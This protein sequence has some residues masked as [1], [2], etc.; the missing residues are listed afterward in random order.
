MSASHTDIPSK[1]LKAQTE[2]CKHTQPHVHDSA[3]SLRDLLPHN[4]TDPMARNSGNTNLAGQNVSPGL[5][6]A[7]SLSQLMSEHA[8][9]SK[10]SGIDT[11]QGFGISSLGS[12]PVG[13][14]SHNQNSLSLGTLASLNMSAASPGSAPSLLS[15]SLSSLSLNNPKITTT[16]SS[17]APPPGFGSLNLALQGNR[18]PTGVVTGVKAPVISPKGGP[19]LADLIQEHSNRSPTAVNSFLVQKSSTTSGTSEGPAVPAQSLSLSELAMQHENKKTSTEELTNMLTTSK[20]TNIAPAC[21]GGTVSLS[22]LALQQQT[23]SKPRADALKQP[24]ASSDMLSL[25]HLESAHKGKTSTTSNGSEYSL[26]SLLLPAK[27]ESAGVLAES[28][29]EGGTKRLN[30]RPHHQSSRTPKPMQM[31]DLSTLMAQSE[32]KCPR[33]SEQDLPSPVSPPPVASVFAKP[34]VFALTLS[35]QNRRQQRRMRNVL[36]GKIRTQRDGSGYQAFL[37]SSQEKAKEQQP[38]PSPIEPFTFDTPS[39]D[40][41]VRANQRKAFTR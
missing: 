3:L 33:L 9:K 1:T 7:V 19:S 30:H 17:L 25:S 22:Q 38:P 4:E 28:T 27:P 35:I 29:T 31:I 6:G 23:S 18:H 12:P 21:L 11:G 41:I 14:N 15:V 2:R 32:G 24:P 34:S 16:S 8:Q 13:P 37:C 20:C 10:T 5:S 39:P 36:K 40:D 26:T